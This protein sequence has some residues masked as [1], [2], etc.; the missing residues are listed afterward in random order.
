[1]SPYERE[2]QALHEAYERG[3]I[4]S[5]ELTKELNELRRDYSAQAR[6]SARDAYDREME[7]W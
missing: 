2:E 6:E 4:T 3:E 7:R 1:M 5:Q